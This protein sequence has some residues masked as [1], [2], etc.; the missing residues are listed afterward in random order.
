[1]DIRSSKA[2]LTKNYFWYKSKLD[3]IQF[4]FDKT[5]PQGINPQEQK[6]L[7]LGVGTGDD[8]SLLKKYGKIFCIDTDKKAIDALAPGDCFEKKI[9]SACTIGYPDNYFDM[10]AALDVLEYIEDDALAAKEICRVLKPGGFFVLTL[11]ALPLL[12]SAHDRY[13][14]HYRRYTVGRVKAILS[15][16]HCLKIG[17]WMFLLFLPMAVTK[18]M[19]KKGSRIVF[20]R[21]PAMINNILY[22][23]CSLENFLIRH[24]FPLPIGTTIYGIYQKA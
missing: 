13:L 15:S 21:M 20:M 10:V 23:V 24:N 16:M 5:N 3:L 7:N 9:S 19:N 14:G 2:G 18:L 8:L 6:I 22:S 4:L 11:P 1:M 17:Y 12:Y